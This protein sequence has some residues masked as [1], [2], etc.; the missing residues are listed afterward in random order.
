MRFAHMADCHLGAWNNHPEL[1]E[2]PIKAFETAMD[3]CLNE[4]IDFI[5]ISGDLFDTSFP[6]IDV[7]RRAVSKIRQCKDYGMAVYAIPGS[8]DFSPTGKTFLNVLD[9]AGLLRNVAKNEKPS[10]IIDKKTNTK[11]IGIAG[12]AGSLD[13]G[14]FES[15]D[16]SIE[17][18]HGFK[19]FMFHCGIENYHG[20]GIPLSL[21][22]KNF[23]YYAGGH[24]HKTLDR[25]ES[26]HGRVAFPGPLFPTDF[27]ELSG[28]SGFFI[29]NASNNRIMMQHKR[30]K[31]CDI[32]S[33]KIDAGGK[34]ADGIE[35]EIA[36]GMGDISGKILLLKIEGVMDGKPG[37]IDFRKIYSLAKSKGA[38]AIKKNTGKLAAKELE[39]VTVRKDIA[40]EEMEK[41]IIKE[42]A[43]KIK[44]NTEDEISLTLSLMKALE[45]EKQE[46]ETTGSFEER[47]IG[48]AKKVLNLS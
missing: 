11:I 25:E 29:V 21:L 48:S 15:L 46:G 45:E 9:D 24:I 39:E 44:V 32:V 16:K 5:L 28:D 20:M 13:R 31:I 12:R 6:P 37:D 34:S 3:L 38:F 2:L 30:V 7:L 10:F 22:P 47:I 42:H 17:R 23:D 14:A 43:G 26:G 19:V 18:E 33:I 4:G 27:D 41:E 8:H 36:N 40:I 35:D 1:R